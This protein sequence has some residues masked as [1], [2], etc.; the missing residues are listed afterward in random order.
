M[1]ASR[2]SWWSRPAAEAESLCARRPPR[3]APGNPPFPRAT[4]SRS[5]NGEQATLHMHGATPGA[6][7]P[8]R[9]WRAGGPW[10]WRV[11]HLLKV[12]P[13]LPKFERSDLYIGSRIG[14]APTT[15]QRSSRW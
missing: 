8:S 6:R 5:I 10:P 15:N 4:R 14:T 7:R 3:P 9:C 12:E 13:G 11:R 1:T 2:A